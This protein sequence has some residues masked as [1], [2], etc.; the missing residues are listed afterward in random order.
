ML[1]GKKVGQ[2]SST[3]GGGPN[4][5]NLVMYKWFAKLLVPR[6][7]CKVCGWGNYVVYIEI[8]RPPPQLLYVSQPKILGP[9]VEEVMRREVEESIS[10]EAEAAF[11]KGMVSPFGLSAMNEAKTTIWDG[12]AA[13]IANE[14]S[15][16]ISGKF[17]QAS[18][19]TDS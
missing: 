3:P 2:G 1:V 5:K 13:A 7:L 12:I 6:H 19:Y 8:P 11:E 15:L 18:C 17:T 9:V 4:P 14:H 16:T 10:E